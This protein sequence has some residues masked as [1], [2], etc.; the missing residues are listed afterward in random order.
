[1]DEH[2]DAVIATPVGFLGLRADSGFLVRVE[3]LGPQAV[4]I[5]PPSGLLREAQRQLA[6]W[7]TD[8]VFQFTIPCRLDGTAFQRKVWEQIATI[9][10]GAVRTYSEVAKTIGSAPRAVGGA[11]GANPLPI[12]VP[13]H[14]VVAAH[15]IGG[16]NAR[17]D[18]LDWLSIKRWLLRHEQER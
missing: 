11:C 5:P 6:V 4:E 3:F 7:F 13:C 15:G 12:V 9:P 1:M 14:R 18:G 10:C 17:R 2:F 16:F 8:P